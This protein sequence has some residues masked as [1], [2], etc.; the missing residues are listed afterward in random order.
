MKNSTGLKV[1]VRNGALIGIEDQYK[2]KADY[3]KVKAKLPFE[4]KIRELLSMQ[5]I[6]NAVGKSRRL[7]D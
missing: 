4:E 3:H 2:T 1:R 6:V 5:K 7:A